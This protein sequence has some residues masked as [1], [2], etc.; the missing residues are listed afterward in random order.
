MKTF[1][2]YLAIGVLASLIGGAAT[3]PL[4][5]RQEQAVEAKRCEWLAGDLHIHTTYSHDSYGGPEDD[6]TGPEEAYT[7]G[8]TTESQFAV[9]KSRGL[10]YLAITDHNDIRS[11]QHFADEPIAS[12]GVIPIGG[13][14]NSLKGHAQML[15]A[16]KLYDSD[17]D[18]SFDDSPEGVNA[19]AK[20]LRADGGLL[21]INHPSEG[22]VEADHLDWEYDF[23]VEP[24]TIEVWNISRLYQPPFPSASSNDDAIDYWEKWLDRGAKIGATGGSDNHYVATTGAQGAGQPTTWVCADSSNETGVLDGLRAGRTFISHQP[25]NHGGPEIY[26]EADKDSDNDYESTVGATVAP[27]TPLR[28]R[29][30][31]APGAMLRLTKTGGAVLAE[32]PVTS[33]IFEHRFTA[34]QNDKW[35]RAEILQQDGQAQRQQAC[36]GDVGDQTTYCRNQLLVLGMTSAIYFEAPEPEGNPLPNGGFLV[37]ADKTSLAPQPERYQP[38]GDRRTEES[39][40]PAVW[41]KDPVACNAI[42]T[43]DDGNPTMPDPAYLDKPHHFTWPDSQLG[44]PDHNPNCIYLGGY[45]LGPLR[46]AQGV[47]EA[48]VWVRSV[49]ISNGARTVVFQVFDTVGFF[50]RYRND[51]CDRCGLLDIREA[52]AAREG[53]GSSKYVTI[54]STHTHGG[55]DTYGG[56]GGVP[57]WYWHQM[58]DA[59]IDSAHEAIAALEPAR[60]SV[61]QVQAPQFN[62]ERR[63]NYYSTPD[64]GAVWMSAE[65]VEGDPLATL[66][67]Y[68]AHPVE[69]DWDNKNLHADWPGRFNAGLEEEMPGSVAMTIEGGLGNVSPNG[70]LENMGPVFARFIKHDIDSGGDELTSNYIEAQAKVISHPITNGPE[71]ALGAIGAFD[72]EFIPGTQGAD[73]PGT[74]GWSKQGNPARGCNTAGPIQIRTPVAGYRIGELNVFTG[75]GELF[76]NM[77]EVV[78]SNARTGLQTMVFGNANDSLGYII[79]SF[80]YDRLGGVATDNTVGEYE[81]TFALDPCFGDHVLDEILKIN[82]SLQTVAAGPPRPS[83]RDRDGVPNFRD[84]C[85]NTFNPD[86]QDSDGDEVGDACDDSTDPTTSPS[87]SGTASGSPSPS[88]SPS[89]SASPSES[90]SESASPSES[91]SES[92]SPSAS[93]SPSPSEPPP[94]LDRDRDGVPDDVDN[95]PDASNTGQANA[96]GDSFGDACEPDFDADGVSDDVDNCRTVDNPGQVDGDQ[97]G[98]GDACE[99]DTDGDGVIDDDDNCI[100]QPNS[101]QENT[102]GDERGDA[103]EPAPDPGGGGNG[104]GGG[105]SSGSESPSPTPTSQNSGAAEE[106]GEIQTTIAADSSLIRFGDSLTLSGTV[107]APRMCGSSFVVD[108]SRREFGSDSFEV[109]ATLEVGEDLVWT[110]TGLPKTNASYLATARDSGPCDGSGSTPVDVLVKVKITASVPDSCARRATIRGSVAPSRPGSTVVLQRKAA[111]EWH[112][113]DADNLN[114]RSRYALETDSCRGRHRIVWKGPDIRNERSALNFRLNK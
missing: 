109:I 93:G 96:D 51:V 57:K 75:P 81:E 95:C 98:T 64:F 48:G 86:Q 105:G 113:V 70:G 60:I 30:V 67:N 44:W 92:G 24:D 39:Q 110:Y 71:F 10:D 69:T 28:V 88:E 68:A 94:P 47:D 15:G 111:G 21:Q 66:L 14:E 2:R 25:P 9:A 7:A 62:N 11:Q 43:D 16:H 52:I 19:A 89:E 5:A 45:G 101:T 103:C 87:P 97:D 56:W 107:A 23:D 1:T 63:D 38:N 76:S 46:G 77:T 41:E 65:S 34:G 55:A 35:V 78:K 74:Y 91:P 42:P 20:E 83:D 82:A 26:L 29:V 6:N 50:H 13:Y 61:G 53:L 40:T 37:G 49:A 90:P 36:D 85:P 106:T 112:R 108:L 3:I 33:P 17:L 73:G 32:V 80:E 31:G 58:R 84:N 12:S 104:G 18:P 54:A 22:Q 114:R 102:Y 72:R 79:Q 99:G 27:S 100:A 4:N 59:A 8:H